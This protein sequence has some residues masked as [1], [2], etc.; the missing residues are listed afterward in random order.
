MARTFT[1]SCPE[2][3]ETFSAKTIMGAQNQAAECYETHYPVQ[4]RDTK[5]V[6]DEIKEAW[7]DWD[8]GN[9]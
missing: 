5:V 2:C 6:M 8:G 9:K 1:D 7:P 3:G 4:T